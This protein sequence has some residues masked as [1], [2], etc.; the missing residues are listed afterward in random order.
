MLGEWLEE[1]AEFIY[2]KGLT[3]YKDKAKVYHAFDEKAK[4]LNPPISSQALHTWFYSLRS[5]FGRLTAEKSGQ[6][7][8]RRLTDRE[9][10]ILNIFLFLRPH[11]VRQGK[12]KVLGLPQVRYSVCFCQCSP[13]LIFYICI[14]F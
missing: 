8:S 1:E 4:T 14:T 3:E 7:S 6:G 5:R 2:N 12:P 9:R 10:W 11:I 13:P